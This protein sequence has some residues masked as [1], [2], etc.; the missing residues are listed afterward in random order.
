MR[1]DNGNEYAI[2]V[3]CLP[4]FGIFASIA[5]LH[6]ALYS[7]TPHVVHD[8]TVNEIRVYMGLKSM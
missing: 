5:V 8:H 2:N 6:L 7:V 1:E 4:V 3:Y